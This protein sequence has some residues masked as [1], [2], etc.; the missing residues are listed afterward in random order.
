MERT[1]TK[2]KRTPEDDAY[3]EGVSCHMY[4]RNSTFAD[5]PYDKEKQSTL[6][7]QWEQGYYDSMSDE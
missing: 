6:W 3:S 2:Y 7:K 5:N 1:V 4:D